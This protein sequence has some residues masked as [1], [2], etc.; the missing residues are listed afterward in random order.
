YQRNRDELSQSRRPELSTVEYQKQEHREPVDDQSI[1]HSRDRTQEPPRPDS[2]RRQHYPTSYGPIEPHP[3]SSGAYRLAKDS[4]IGRVG[5]EKYGR[6][7]SY[8]KDPGTAD[9]SRR[10]ELDRY[11]PAETQQPSH[12]Q[13]I[14]KE[15]RE[16]S[17]NLFGYT[18][19][20]SGD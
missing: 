9:A 13:H 20:S 15:P 10:E 2:S 12:A 6:G 18:H 19:G 4:E 16:A 8:R 5:Y 7:S 11:R 3:S 17:S 14:S 1:T